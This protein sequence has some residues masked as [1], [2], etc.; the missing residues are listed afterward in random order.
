[1]KAVKRHPESTPHI[2]STANVTEALDP[3]NPCPAARQSKPRA[4]AP[5][6]SAVASERL[7]V[8]FAQNGFSDEKASS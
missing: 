2:A 6:S 3:L 4:S 7:A 1:M 8:D 5:P